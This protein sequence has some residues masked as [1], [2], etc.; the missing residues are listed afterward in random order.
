MTIVDTHCHASPVWFEP[1]ETLLFQMDR[2]G[3]AQAVLTQLLGQYDNRYQE[4]CCAR[5]PNR[6]ASVVAVDPAQPGAAQQLVAL[7]A[8][9]ARGVRLRPQARS[10]G[11]DPLELWRTAETCGIVVSCVGPAQSFITAEFAQLLQSLPGLTF[12]LEHLGG[13]ARPDC[14]GDAATRAGILALARYSNVLLKIPGLGQIVKRDARLP[15]AGRALALEP[16]A[17]VLE[18]LAHYGPGRLMWG[19]DFPPVASREGYANALAWVSEL[20][21]EL[22]QAAQS[23]ILGGTAPRVFRLGPVAAAAAESRA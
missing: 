19:S 15:A 10:P 2:A 11:A 7:A 5:F 6:L 9:G 14:D 12:V 16:A 8:A 17:V 18:A 23:A 3:V 1:V 13:W 22:P 21:A 20:L 4:R